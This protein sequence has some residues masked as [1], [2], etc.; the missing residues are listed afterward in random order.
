[1][2][3]TDNADSIHHL[4]PQL[5][6]SRAYWLGWGGADDVHDDL[7]TYRSDVAHPLLNGVLRLRGKRV[8]DVLPEIRERLD[9]LS[10]LWWVGADSDPEVADDLLAVGAAEVQTLP[11]MALDLDRL[12]PIPWP[13]GLTVDQFDLVRIKHPAPPARRPRLP[14]ART[15]VPAE[16]R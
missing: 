16:C 2:T 5:A 11:I 8:P 3:S 4:R 1:M 12:P 9:G 6:N 15:G 14:T 13:A 7:V 10:R